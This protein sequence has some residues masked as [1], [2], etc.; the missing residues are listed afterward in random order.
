VRADAVADAPD[1][2]AEVEGDEG[3][4]GLLVGDVE[5][6]VDGAGG[7]DGEE[8]GEGE[9]ELDEV[10]GLETDPDEDGGE[11]DGVAGGEE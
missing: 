9:D 1:E 3:G 2:G 6:A 10:A 8:A 4:E 5:G 7:G 11:G